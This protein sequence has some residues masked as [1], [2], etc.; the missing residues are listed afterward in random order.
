MRSQ[1]CER[2]SKEARLQQLG[3]PALLSAFQRVPVPHAWPATQGYAL[4]HLTRRL[5][6]A[7]RHVTLRLAEL[8][9][10][11]GHAAGPA[12][13][14]DAVRRLKERLCYVAADLPREQQA[15]ARARPLLEPRRF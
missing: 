6:I 9:R 13:T 14:L 1:Q 11:R 3:A 4:P 8:L 5:D 10:R 7:G 2:P 15:R 12:A